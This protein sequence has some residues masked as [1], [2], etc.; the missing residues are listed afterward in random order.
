MSKGFGLLELPGVLTSRREGRPL[1]FLCLVSHVFSAQFVAQFVSH[2]S[3]LL[4]DVQ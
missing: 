4:N 1:A 2:H 3:E